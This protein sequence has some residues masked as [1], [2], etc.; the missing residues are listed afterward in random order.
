MERRRSQAEKCLG[1]AKLALDGFSAG[2]HLFGL[3]K[4][5]FSMIDLAAAALD[6][7]GPADVAVWIWCIADYE[8][9][10]V[11]AFLDDGRVDRFRLVMD[12]AGVQRDLPLVQDMQ[13]RFGVDCIRVTKTHAKIVTIRAGDWRL[14]IR[15]SM[16]LNA[17][18]RFE[19]FDISD[20]PL[21]YDLVE[22]VMLEM[23][24][25]GRPLPVEQLDHADAAGL[26]DFA[27]TGAA[28]P[29]CPTRAAWWPR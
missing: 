7:T 26:L 17:N 29:W 18:P 13:R 9:E 10:A 5:Q 24:Q 22:G 1:T 14:V 6:V 27:E 12:W 3:T 28:A 16:N 8:V 11:G 2:S 21:A 25:R 23:W 20:S 19:Q 15:G 4:G